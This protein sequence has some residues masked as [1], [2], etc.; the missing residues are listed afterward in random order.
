[1]SARKRNATQG[2][3]LETHRCPDCGIVYR[4]PWRPNRECPACGHT[5]GD[6][7]FP[8]S[9]PDEWPEDPRD[10]GRGGVTR[11]VRA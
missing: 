3:L 7:E 11:S 10:P 9:G 2:R 1:M 8:D 4:G 6:A 5:Y